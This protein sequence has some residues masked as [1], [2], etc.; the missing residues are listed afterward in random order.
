MTSDL[1][2]PG[3]KPRQ[4]INKRIWANSSQICY[5]KP[6]SASKSRLSPTLLMSLFGRNEEA[7]RSGVRRVEIDVHDTC[8]AVHARKTLVVFR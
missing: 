3:S 6:N 1:V 7:K 4:R 5:F 2:E 8:G